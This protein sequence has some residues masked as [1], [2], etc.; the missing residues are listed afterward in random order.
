LKVDE[1]GFRRLMAEQRD[2]AKADAKSKK[3]G[4]ADLSE[5]RKIAESFGLS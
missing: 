1:E 2:R 5:Y 3:A 4:H